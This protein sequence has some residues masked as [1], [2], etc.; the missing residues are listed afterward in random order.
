MGLDMYLTKKNYIGAEYEHRK[1]KGKVEITIDGKPVPITF[2][3][4][5]YVI[6]KVG[7]WRKA[8]AIHGWF[9]QNIQRG[10]DDCGEYFV[11][12]EK[13]VELRNLCKSILRDTNLVTLLPPTEGFFFGSDKVDHYYYQDLEETIRIINKLCPYGDYYYQS[14]W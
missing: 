13:L 14:S 5:Q 4:I 11:P 3:N 8:N 7:Y 1:V 12:F 6:E 9:V 10:K 2:D